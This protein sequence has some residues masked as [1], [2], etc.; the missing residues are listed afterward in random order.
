MIAAQILGQRD[1]LLG[2]RAGD[3]GIRGAQMGNKLRGQCLHRRRSFV[4]PRLGHDDQG[5][6]PEAGDPKKPRPK[7]DGLFP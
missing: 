4:I 5:R 1:L 7:G 3:R 6:M 2:S